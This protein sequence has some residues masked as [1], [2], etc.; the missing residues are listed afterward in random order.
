[1][2]NFICPIKKIKN[3]VDIYRARSH[4]AQ[5]HFLSEVEKI[6]ALFSGRELNILCCD[7][8]IELMKLD[9]LGK[10]FVDVRFSSSL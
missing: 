7:I 6:T 5:A 4:G 8:I 9:N 2:L 10:L 3:F 1:M